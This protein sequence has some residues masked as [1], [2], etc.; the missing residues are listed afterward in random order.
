MALTVNFYTFAKKDN[1]TARPT[2]SPAGSYSC[3]LKD[4]CSVESPALVL[5]L[6][7]TTNPSAWNYCHI[8]DFNRY[9]YVRWS[10]EAGLWSA[11]LQTDVM[12]TYKTQIGNA[13]LYV[14]RSAADSNGSIGDAMYPILTGTTIDVTQGSLWWD[15]YHSTSQGA[16]GGVFVVGLLSY[17]GNNSIFGGVN[18]ALFTPNQMMTFLQTIYAPGGNPYTYDYLDAR[19]HREYTADQIANMSYTVENP[20]LDYVKSVMFIPC[21][22]IADPVV[23]TG[24][25]MGSK[26]FEDLQ[27]IEFNPALP[28]DFHDNFSVRP[29]PQHVGRG[30]YL[31]ADPY[32]E[33]FLLLPR[34]GLVK[35]DSSLFAEELFMY[36]ALQVDP[37]SGMGLYSIYRWYTDSDDEQHLMEVQRMSA[38][39]GVNVALSQTKDIGQMLNASLSSLAPLASLASGNITGAVMQAGAAITNIQQARETNGGVIGS[40]DGFLGLQRDYRRAYLI[41][42][43]HT[44][45]DDDPTHN[46]KP[47]CEVRQISTLPG[48]N[49]VMDGDVDIPGTAGE[50]AEVKSYLE[51]GFFYE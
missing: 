49:K 12:A 9:Y 36:V 2:G 25:W 1:S 43:F 24:L 10:Y 33:T 32:T 48:Y 5:N 50:A 30:N 29:H 18:Y 4:G 51:G 41:R 39:I 8:P 6:G 16:S 7:T 37:I 23:L 35:V 31:N 45:A 20:F 27:H 40:N 42:L 21:G 44:V 3:I 13:N 17:I 15:N 28:F 22:Q 11:S 19:Y 46:G 14:L 34:A 38:Q 47:L 26:Y